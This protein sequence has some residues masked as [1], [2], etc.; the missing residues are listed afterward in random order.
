M[1]EDFGC[2][3]V[4]CTKEDTTSNW[5]AC[6]P[7]PDSFS[8]IHLLSLCGMKFYLKNGGYR[9]LLYVGIHLSGYAPDIG[10]WL[11]VTW[12]SSV[13]THGEVIMITVHCG[14]M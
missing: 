11:V 9:F 2:K 13:H 5:L 12:Y 7:C 6:C 3:I 10:L 4:R 14:L 1:S 8:L